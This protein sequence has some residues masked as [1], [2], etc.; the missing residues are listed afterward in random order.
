MPSSARSRIMATEGEELAQELR[1]RVSGE[2]RFDAYSRLLYSTDASIY[3]M[4]PV[5]VVIPRNS[6]DVL[7]VMEVAAQ[8]MVP[9]LPRC[10][11]T[12]LAG[13]TVNHAIVMDFSKYMHEVLEVNEEERWAR[14][15][16]GIVLDILNRHLSSMK[17]QYAP[18]P[19]TSNRACV[20][21]GIG[22]NTC[23]SHSVIYG[24]T[25]D[26]IQ[27]VSVVLSDGAQARFG[28]LDTDELQRKMAAPTFEGQIYTGTSCELRSRT[29]MRWLPGT[30][31]SCAGSAATTWT[32][33]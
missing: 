12:S 28:P 19:T 15:Q 5:G 26:H 30:P 23:G 33:P 20:G 31:G 2:V 16:P 25:V 27:E 32:N 10:G 3:Q 1:K 4:D 7:A 13:Q 29:G 18:D 17:L 11:G 22:N 24:K 14:V 21:G 6:E 9:V 8:N